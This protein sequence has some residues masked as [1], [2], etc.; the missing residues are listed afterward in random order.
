[1]KNKISLNELE[2]IHFA[3][4][5]DILENEPNK[6]YIDSPDVIEQRF[7]A[8]ISM[9]SKKKLKPK[10]IKG[11][12]IPIITEH[13]AD[14]KYIV[15][16]SASIIAKVE[17]DK[18]IRN[19]EK[20]LKIKIGSGYPSDSYTINAIIKDLSKNKLFPYVRAYWETYK[21]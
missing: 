6:I 19:I 11:E 14:S 8:K 5:I 10:G 17:R 18:A 21:K 20:S 16:S 15:V 1:M 12:G 4:L 9:Y 2:A 7:G 3:K 13:K